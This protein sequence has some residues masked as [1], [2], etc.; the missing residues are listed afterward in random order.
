MRYSA[1]MT[2]P[3]L[4]DEKWNQIQQFVP[5]Q[6]PRPN[7]GRPRPD[8]RRTLTA[9]LFVLRSGIPWRTLPREMGYGSGATARRLLRQWQAQG[10][11]QRL[12]P[13]LV[14]ELGE[15]GMQRARA[16]REPEESPA[17]ESP[18][19]AGLKESRSRRGFARSPAPPL[20]P[21]PPW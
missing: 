16:L 3:L 17:A 20:L 12:L 9:I 7:G 21:Y 4:T 15:E 14:Q 19:S 10:V 6:P 18:G 13:H 1:S 11:W 8:A 5:P 2:E